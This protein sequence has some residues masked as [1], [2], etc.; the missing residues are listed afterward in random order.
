MKCNFLH[1][2]LITIIA[3]ISQS[4][5]EGLP[6]KG[7]LWFTL[8]L[9]IGAHYSKI[10]NEEQKFINENNIYLVSKSDSTITKPIYYDTFNQI[11]NISVQ[12]QKSP[13]YS[14][15]INYQIY[16]VQQLLASQV[17][18]SGTKEILFLNNLG[19][20]FIKWTNVIKHNIN[21]SA[22]PKLFYGKLHRAAVLR[23]NLSKF[24]ADDTEFVSLVK[25]YH[26]NL[27]VYGFGINFNFN[28]TLIQRERMQTMLGLGFDY[29]KLYFND[30]SFEYIDNTYFK[31][32]NLSV[33]FAFNKKSKSPE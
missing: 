17:G 16:S 19:P 32:F 9:G 18:F 22:S 6:E 31:S 8:E 13:S 33:V 5:A 15:G 23:K 3:A 25:N 4:Y 30:K 24:P 27:N 12:Y 14:Y 7:T 28:F 11:L 2:I 26:N 10:K 20:V 29:S 21:F 1:I